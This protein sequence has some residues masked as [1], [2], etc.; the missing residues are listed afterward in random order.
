MLWGAR[1]SLLSSMVGANP[2]CRP[3]GGGA[4]RHE[5]TGSVCGRRS[6]QAVKRQGKEANRQRNA[7]ERQRRIRKIVG[8]CVG[9]RG[10][11]GAPR[12]RRRWRPCRTFR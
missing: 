3:N 5:I 6:V 2:P 9:E 12:H 4:I 8:A 1:T 7:K 10:G 11:G